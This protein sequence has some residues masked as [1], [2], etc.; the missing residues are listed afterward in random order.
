MGLVGFQICFEEE[1]EGGLIRD[2]GHCSETRSEQVHIVRYYRFANLTFVP[3][4]QAE[5]NE[6]SQRERERERDGGLNC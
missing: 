6:S 3:Y 5:N 4:F 1:E 2:D